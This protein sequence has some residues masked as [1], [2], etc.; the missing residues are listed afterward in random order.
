LVVAEI[1][2]ALVLVAGATLL[3][4]TFVGLQ[5]V[6]PGFDSHNVLTLKTSMGGASYTT[7]AKVDAFVTQAVRRIEGIAGVEAVASTLMLPVECCVDLPF[8]IVGKP[9]TQ[10]QYN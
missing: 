1:A 8:N 5:N 6:N 7:T 9:P 2:L 10:G 3:I 4:R